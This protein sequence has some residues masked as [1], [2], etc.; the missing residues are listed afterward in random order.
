[1]KAPSKDSQQAA[2]P[3]QVVAQLREGNERFVAGNRR[4]HD[5]ELLAQVE[6]TKGGQAPLAA[7]V[8]CIDS[9][10]SPEYAFDQPIGS[11]FAARLAGNVINAE[12]LGSLEFA[13]KVAGSKVIMVLGHTACGAVKGACDRVELGNLTKLLSHIQP[14]VASTMPDLDAAERSSAN[15][16][17]V[18]AVG[19]Q[20]IH[21]ALETI[22][23]DSPILAEM[24]STGE[25]KLVGA[26]YDVGTGKVEFLS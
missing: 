15:S 21:N 8:G 1:M 6:A 12:V 16:E 23:K 2:T 19:I 14:A 3:D 9:R 11:I 4:N 26:N 18:N 5:S 13:C 24:E 20:N 7:I 10:V 25:I 22:R 17:F